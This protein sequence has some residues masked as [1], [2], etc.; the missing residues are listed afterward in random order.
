MRRIRGRAAESGFLRTRLGSNQGIV[1]GRPATPA[2]RWVHEGDRSGWG[3]N[4]GTGRAHVRRR[5]TA[6]RQGAATGA[7]NPI[8]QRADDRNRT[9]ASRSK[10]QLP[11]RQNVQLCH[12]TSPISNY[13]AIS[14]VRGVILSCQ[15]ESFR[16]SGATPPPRAGREAAG[17]PGRYR[18]PSNGAGRRRRSGP[19]RRSRPPR[20]SG[21]PRRCGRI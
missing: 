12:D 6:T 2:G 7:T 13:V 5:L 8:D 1:P 17:R 16:A 15:E 11:I 14:T 20:R 9:G 3:R 4:Q 18:L 19:R 21:R 10:A